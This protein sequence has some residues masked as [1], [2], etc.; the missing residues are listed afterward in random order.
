MLKQVTKQPAKKLWKQSIQTKTTELKNFQYV[1]LFGI[2]FYFPYRIQR[3][4]KFSKYTGGSNQNGYNS[5]S[6]TIKGV[7]QQVTW[8]TPFLTP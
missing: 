4:L 2:H 6:S 8:F 7:N 3:L 1:L 5:S